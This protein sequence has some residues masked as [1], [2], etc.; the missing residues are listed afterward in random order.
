[1][2][3]LSV[4]SVPLSLLLVTVALTVCVCAVCHQSIFYSYSFFTLLVSGERDRVRGRKRDIVGNELVVALA[5]NAI[6]AQVRVKLENNETP[7]KCVQKA[8]LSFFAN[9]VNRYTHRS[10]T[11]T[12][13]LSPSLSYP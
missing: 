13:S 1:M 3:S 12:L 11:I 6:S 8:S 4:M 2:N 10:P 7:S 5:T 9:S